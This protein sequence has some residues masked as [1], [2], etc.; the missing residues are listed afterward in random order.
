MPIMREGSNFSDSKG[1]IRKPVALVKI[2]NSRKI[3]VR[4]GI[5]LEPRIPNRTRIP[6]TIAIRLMI[7][8]TIV[9]V[10]RLI[11]R[12]M[13]RP[14]FFK[15]RQMLRPATANCH[16]LRLCGRQFRHAPPI[17]KAEAMPSFFAWLSN[18]ANDA[19]AILTI[20]EFDQLRDH[21]VRRFFH[22]PV[23]GSLD[24]HA[25]DVA[26]HH[27]ALLDQERTAGFFS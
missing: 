11:P 18:R 10:A 4:P 9:N 15:P 19:D 26:R 3:A 23:S 8:C 2:V 27:L 14:P 6:E 16:M 12:I 25:L 21:L 5:R 13:T 17:K 1:G 7:T 20:E 22:Q 24:E